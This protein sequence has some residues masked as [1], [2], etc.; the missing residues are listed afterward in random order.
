MT[1]VSAVILSQQ[2]S[3]CGGV[4]VHAAPL[5]PLEGNRVPCTPWAL[6]LSPERGVNCTQIHC[7]VSKIEGYANYPWKWE[8]QDLLLCK[9]VQALLYLVNLSIH[10]GPQLWAGDLLSSASSRVSLK[11]LLLL[12]PLMPSLATHHPCFSRWQQPAKRD[13]PWLLLASPWLM[14]TVASP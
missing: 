11:V 12:I 14:D 13:Q 8:I 6:G 1:H 4:P 3:N 2:K 5:W 7:H 10:I 9:V